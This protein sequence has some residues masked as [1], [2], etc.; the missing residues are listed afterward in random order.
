MTSLNAM[1]QLAPVLGEGVTTEIFV[2]LIVKLTSDPVAN[3]RFSAARTLG[4]VA[5]DVSDAE[6]KATV[7]PCLQALETGSAGENDPEVRFFATKSL[8]LIR[9]GPDAFGDDEEPGARALAQGLQEMKI[10]TS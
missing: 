5:T 9:D 10:S 6:L 4:R 8:T 1:K 2:P 3:V 7:V